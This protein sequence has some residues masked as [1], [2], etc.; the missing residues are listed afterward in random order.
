MSNSSVNEWEHGM[1]LPELEFDLSQTHVSES[2]CEMWN[3]KDCRVI[4]I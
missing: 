4:C 2:L 3:V 1:M